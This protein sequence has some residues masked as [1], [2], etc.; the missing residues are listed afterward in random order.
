MKRLLKV[1]FCIGCAVLFAYGQAGAN[2]PAWVAELSDWQAHEVKAQEIEITVP[3]G[4]YVTLGVYNTDAV[5]VVAPEGITHEQFGLW[6][7]ART[8]YK[9]T[10]HQRDMAVPFYMPPSRWMH[11]QGSQTVRL[12]ADKPGSYCIV[13]KCNSDTCQLILTVT[14]AVP[15]SDTGLGFYVDY[16]RFGYYDKVNERKYFEDMANHGCNTTTFY[17]SRVYT[18]DP[19]IAKRY[20]ASGPDYKAMTHYD[21]GRQFDLAAEVGL[22][23]PDIPVFGFFGD[24]HNLLSDL[25]E[26]KKLFPERADEWPEV[27]GYNA[28]EAGPNQRPIME[29]QQAAWDGL[30]VR[31]GSATGTASLFA[32]SDVMD[33]WLP[34]VTSWTPL[35][36]AKA[37]EEGAELGQYIC[38]WRGTNAPMHRYMTGIWRWITRPKMLLLWS[39]MHDP[40]SRVDPDGKWN[41]K[42][43]FEY[44][45]AAPDGPISTVGLEGFRDG[46]VDYRVLRELERVLRKASKERTGLAQFDHIVPADA[47]GM[48]DIQK[49]AT[50][51]ANVSQMYVQGFST[52]QPG[53]YVADGPDTMIPP[54][55]CAAVREEAI[56]WIRKLSGEEGG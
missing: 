5:E 29:R 27:L 54:A 51:L 36:A 22:T 9:D 39:Y 28:D 37:A 44:A 35:L 46:A 13:L 42:R 53:P 43:S 23:D 7:E 19:E 31:N 6:Y 38:G 32:I 24:G 3:A 17:T 10:P 20:P 49:C 41:A 48:A 30:D 1:V 15:S 33:L 40:K 2:Q 45:L 12:F 16:N 52:M 4:E 21:V 18:A 11:Q 55:D 14:P 50:F 26:A 34:Y 8:V 47:P 56:E 25:A